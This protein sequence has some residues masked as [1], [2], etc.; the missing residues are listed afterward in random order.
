MNTTLD[1]INLFTGICSRRKVFVNSFFDFWI[2]QSNICEGLNQ[3]QFIVFRGGIKRTEIRYIVVLLIIENRLK[4][5][6][7][8][9]LAKFRQLNVEQNS[10][11]LQ[12]IKQPFETFIYRLKRLPMK[13]S[14]FC[15]FFIGY[16]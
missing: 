12:S 11:F 16:G 15:I 3:L 6:L 7:L 13:F 8:K 4:G 2:D 1:L 5:V 9:V 10:V 14:A